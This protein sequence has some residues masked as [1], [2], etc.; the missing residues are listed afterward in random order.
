VVDCIVKKS[1]I[2]VFIVTALI[3]F[4]L[5]FVKLYVGLGAN[6]ISIYSDGINN[7][8]DS[9]SCVAAIVCFSL[10]L[11]SR[12][13]FSGALAKRTELLFSLALS[14]VILAVGAA[15]LYNSAE[16]L[17]YPTPVWFAVNYFCILLFTASVKLALF[18][19]LNSRARRLGSE[20]VRLMSVDSLTDFFVTAVTVLTL[21]LSK[22]GSYSF[23]A[24]GGIAIS[25][26]IIITAVKSIKKNALLLIGLPETEKREATQ[27]LLGAVIDGNSYEAEFSLA[28][29][30][31]V[32]VKTEK[33]FCASELEEL[34]KNIYNETGLKLYVL[35]K[36]E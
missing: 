20:T 12:D 18:F 32:F 1:Y 36:E 15:F 2:P 10:L 22:N 4:V 11:K 7:L 8:F 28:A 34:K 13:C 19:F 31:C 17:M 33:K 6:S 24:L 26:F 27:R 9:L 21:L 16:R 14:C 30:E 25:I 3:N 29:E 35:K 23:D 5:F